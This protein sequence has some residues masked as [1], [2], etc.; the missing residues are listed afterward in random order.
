M[1]Q[2]LSKS[3]L[4]RM[5]SWILILTP[6]WV[7]VPGLGP[8][9]SEKMGCFRFPAGW[10]FAEIHPVGDCVFFFRFYFSELNT[11]YLRLDIVTNMI[12][13]GNEKQY[14]SKPVF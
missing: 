5:T 1:S 10:I 11:E 3:T 2:K 13:Q 6:P 9:H 12:Y 14:Q 8:G 4:V 7:V